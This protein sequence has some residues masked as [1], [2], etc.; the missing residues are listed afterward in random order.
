[1][2]DLP[3]VKDISTYSNV[4]YDEIK[5]QAMTGGRE[6]GGE[7]SSGSSGDDSHYA[8]I[9]CDNPPNPN[10]PT[11]RE[12]ENPVAISEATENPRDDTASNPTAPAYVNVGEGA[13]AGAGAEEVVYDLASK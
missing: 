8:T 6:E 9:C 2:T 7:G 11:P 12:Y 4:A 10:L 1:M 5:L 3:G 13:T